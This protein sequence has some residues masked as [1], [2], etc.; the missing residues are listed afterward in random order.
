MSPIGA[1]LAFEQL[2]DAVLEAR[3]VVA[4]P[5]AV[6]PF[7]VTAALGLHVDACHGERMQRGPETGAHLG[8]AKCHTRPFKDTVSIKVYSYSKSV[9]VQRIW[10]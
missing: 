5:Q 1:S 10:K 2:V 8:T 3:V 7:R 6:Q 4:Q 9:P